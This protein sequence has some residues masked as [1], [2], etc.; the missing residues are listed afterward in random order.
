MSARQRSQ[1]KRRLISPAHSKR[2][3]PPLLLNSDKQTNAEEEIEK[4][5]SK[6]VRKTKKK[7]EIFSNDLE[8]IRKTHESKYQRIG[9]LPEDESVESNPAGG[10]GKRYTDDDICSHCQQYLFTRIYIYISLY[11]GLVT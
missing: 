5:T 4:K 11:L 3:F 10:E 9:L 7:G 1:G 8:K 6:Y 2:A